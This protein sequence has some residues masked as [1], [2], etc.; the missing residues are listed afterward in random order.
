MVGALE[1]IKSMEDEKGQDKMAEAGVGR[2][3]G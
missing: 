1:K 2:K 3:S